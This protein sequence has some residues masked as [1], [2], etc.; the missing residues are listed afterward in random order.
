MASE[1]RPLLALPIGTLA[2][3]LRRALLPDLTR[4]QVGDLV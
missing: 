4:L 2:Q 1:Q 3:S